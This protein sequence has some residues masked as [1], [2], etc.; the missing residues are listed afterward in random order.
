MKRCVLIQKN[1]IYFS[2]W[3]KKGYSIF[4]SLGREVHISHLALSMYGSVL[5]KSSGNG[6]I[7]NT[8]HTAELDADLIESWNI[9]EISGSL[10]GE[11]CPDGNRILEIIYK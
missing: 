3:L 7:I 8:D 11:V 1:C 5:L 2:S 9:L 6:V 10:R 4:C